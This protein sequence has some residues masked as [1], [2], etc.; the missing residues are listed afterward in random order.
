[1]LIAVGPERTEVSHASAAEKLGEGFANLGLAHV[2][3]PGA[4][5]GQWDTVG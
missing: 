4:G 5:R 1:M 3:I 2:L